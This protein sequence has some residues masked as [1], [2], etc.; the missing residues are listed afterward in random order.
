MSISKANPIRAVLLPVL[1]AVLSLF[2]KPAISQSQA[3]RPSAAE[4][5]IIS[6]SLLSDVVLKVASYS[7]TIDHTDFL[8]RRKFDVTPISLALPE[9]ERKVKGFKSR[10]ER[11]GNQMNLR[12][13]NSGVI[14]LTEISDKLTSYQKVLSI[15]GNE[16]TQS[17][18][19]VKKIK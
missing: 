19:E 12:S 10:L 17:N 1:I 7:A 16:L 14:M 18:K 2:S 15:Y 5:K 9:L 11:K 6:D 3:E 13:L 8:I 4:K